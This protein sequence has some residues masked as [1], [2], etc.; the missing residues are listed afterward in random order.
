[1]VTI[2]TSIP[3]P[4]EHNWASEVVGERNPG[5]K[6]ALVGVMKDWMGR[7]DLQILTP[8][9]SYSLTHFWHCLPGNA[10]FHMA[11]AQLCRTMPHA[12]S[13]SGST[14]KSRFCLCFCLQLPA[15]DS[16]NLLHFWFIIKGCNSGMAWWKRCTGQNR[17][18]GKWHRASIPSA[19]MA[20]SQHPCV[21]TNPDVHWIPPWASME[22]PSHRQDWL[23]H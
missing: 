15:L 11:R 23:N 14:Q 17:W 20:F 19:C 8:A 1:M 22:A 3:S 18:D 4:W 7:V 2:S 9:V 16:V 6:N 10:W 13:T 5:G 21:F 12:S